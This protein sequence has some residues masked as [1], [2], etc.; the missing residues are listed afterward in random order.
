MVLVERD[1][2]SPS[3][4]TKY[5]VCQAG[6]SFVCRRLHRRRLPGIFRINIRNCF[7]VDVRDRRRWGQ[8]FRVDIEIFGVDVLTEVDKILVSTFNVFPSESTVQNAVPKRRSSTPTIPGS[9]FR[10]FPSRH[11]KLFTCRYS[12]IHRFL[13]EYAISCP[14][15]HYYASL[16]LNIIHT[17]MRPHSDLEL[18]VPFSEIDIFG[19]TTDIRRYADLRKRSEGRTLHTTTRTL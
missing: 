18:S 11:T 8:L 17:A 6:G 2:C 3:V 1:D 16:R 19:R 12:A 14:F 5:F 15:F 9:T 10:I 4:D 7:A 13:P